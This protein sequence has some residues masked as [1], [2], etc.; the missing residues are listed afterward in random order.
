M[1][2]QCLIGRSLIT[3]TFHKSTVQKSPSFVS[4]PSGSSAHLSESLY[5]SYTYLFSFACWL[6]VPIGPQ[7]E[8]HLLRVYHFDM[9]PIFNIFFIVFYTSNIIFQYIFILFYLYYVL[10]KT[11]FKMVSLYTTNELKFVCTL[12]NVNMP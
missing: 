1:G 12:E 2:Y 8:P 6:G 11:V 5:W 4:R 7:W 3:R 9:L 10:I